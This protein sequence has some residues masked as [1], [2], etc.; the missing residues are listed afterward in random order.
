EFLYLLSMDKLFGNKR[1]RLTLIDLEN[2]LGVGRVKINNTIKKYDNYLVK[3]KSRPII[4]EISDE[5]LNSII[6]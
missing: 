4:Y 6:K 3:I 2:I 1:N 5:F